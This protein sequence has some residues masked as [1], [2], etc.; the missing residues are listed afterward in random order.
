M[1]T[2]AIATIAAPRRVLC[3]NGVKALVLSS[4]RTAHR[5]PL[6]SPPCRHGRA[7]TRIHGC[8]R[9]IGPPH[10]VSM[11]DAVDTHVRR[12]ASRAVPDYRHSPAVAARSPATLLLLKA[13]MQS[14]GSGPMSKPQ[15]LTTP[16]LSFLCAVGVTGGLILAQ[17][18]IVLPRAPLPL[19][20]LLVSVLALAAGW[21]ALKMPGVPVYLSISDTFHITS[22]LLFGPAPATLTIALDSLVMSVRR[23]NPA[24]QVHRRCGRRR[25]NF[26]RSRPTRLL[27]PAAHLQRS[28]M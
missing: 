13:D 26:R 17:C 20:W 21:F 25:Y 24:Y 23:G 12:N 3:R 4:I 22:C 7:P 2:A 15:S 27:S 16:L 11:P 18:M 28:T 1:P 10:A 6:A 8:R 9:T 19:G 5:N 14:G